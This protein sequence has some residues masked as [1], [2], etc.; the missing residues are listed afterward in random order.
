MKFSKG[1]LKLDCSAEVNKLSDFLHQHVVSMKR[2]GLVIGLSGGVDSAVCSMLCARALGPE[3]VLAVLLPEK[4]SN[5]LSEE[6]AAK[7]A[8]KIGVRS[9]TVDI[10]PTL[11]GFGTYAKRDDVIREIFPE[12]GP[13]YTSKIVLPPDLLVK[14]SFNY[15]T[16]K[17]MDPQGQV[18]TARLNNQ[19]LRGIVASTNTKQITRM[20]YLNYFADL[21]NFLVCGTTNRSEFIQGFFVKYGDGGVDVEPIEH[22]YKTQV[23]QLAEYLGVMPDIVNRAPSPDTFSFPVTDEEMYFRIPYHTL[24]LLL[25]AWENDV[26]VT[27]LAEAMDFTEIQVRRAF[28]DLN[29][30]FSATRNLRLPPQNLLIP[31]KN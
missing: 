2:D 28:R 5:P 22:L 29:S 18:K 19:V 23:Y 17:V 11:D 4:E 10:T 31:V 26:P 13:G 6:S 21:N 7:H 15:F 12:F 30:K 24:D 20:M 25:Y 16:L 1:I 9:M 8:R 14:D 27:E 3:H